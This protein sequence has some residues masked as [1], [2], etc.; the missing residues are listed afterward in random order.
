MTLKITSLRIDR[1]E[2]SNDSYGGDLSYLIVNATWKVTQDG[3]DEDNFLFD[4]AKAEAAE[5]GKVLTIE[6]P[7]DYE[8]WLLNWDFNF[9]KSYPRYKHCWT[10]RDC[11]WYYIEKF[12]T[13]HFREWIADS[14]VTQALLNEIVYYKATGEMLSKYRTIPGQIILEHFQTLGRYWD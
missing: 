5:Y 1:R 7:E 14:V 8:K 4:L 13:F 6:S 10:H 11:P 12:N 2:S 9:D 3:D